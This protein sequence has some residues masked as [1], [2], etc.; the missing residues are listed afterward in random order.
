VSQSTVVEIGPG[1]GAIT[2][3]LAKRAQRLMLLSWTVNWLHFLKEKFQEQLP[4]I[5]WK[6]T[7]SG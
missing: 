6:K 2:G 3:I 1:K 5:F 4:F 7:Y